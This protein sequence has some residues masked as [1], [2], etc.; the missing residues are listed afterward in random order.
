[1]K[2]Q[3]IGV[4]LLNNHWINLENLFNNLEIPLKLLTKS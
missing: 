3:I 4:E 1:M 2:I